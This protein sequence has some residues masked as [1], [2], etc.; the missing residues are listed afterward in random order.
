MNNK[1]STLTQLYAMAMLLGGS[2]AITPRGY[3]SSSK[4]PTTVCKTCGEH[5]TPISENKKIFCSA[6]CFKKWKDNK[7]TIADLK[8]REDLTLV[9]D[10]QEVRMILYDVGVEEKFDGLFLKVEDATYTEMYGFY[11]AVPTLT[12]TIYKIDLRN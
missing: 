10:S 3:L 2:H 6:K 8:F 12:K 1:S 4:L 5:F 9:N 11:G 7:M